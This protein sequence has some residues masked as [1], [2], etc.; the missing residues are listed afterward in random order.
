[1]RKPGVTF[2]A[3]RQE[4]APRSNLLMPWFR[5]FDDAIQPPKGKKLVTLPFSLSF[6][7]MRS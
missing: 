1:M 3:L 7:R 4:G 6:A 2:K 5:L